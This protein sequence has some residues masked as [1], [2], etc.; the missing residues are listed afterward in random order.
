MPTDKLDV[1]ATC[2][3]PSVQKVLGALRCLAGEGFLRIAV[4]YGCALTGDVRIAYTYRMAHK[5]HPNFE[6]F[7]PENPYNLTRRQ[8]VLPQKWVKNF[9]GIGF[10]VELFDKKRLKT[11]R[12]RPNEEEFVVYRLWEERAEKLSSPIER[13]FF[14]AMDSVIAFP[15]KTI[16]NEFHRAFSA[17]YGLWE[18]RAHLRRSPP[19]DMHLLGI[20]G[21]R[22]TKSPWTKDEEE[23]LERG[24]KTFNRRDAEGG[25]YIPARLGTWTQIQVHIANVSAALAEC[26]WCVI[27]S[28][29]GNFICPDQ[30]LSRVTLL[31]LSPTICVALDQPMPY[32]SVPKSTVIGI[33]QMLCNGADNYFFSMNLSECPR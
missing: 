20:Q 16:S 33:N 23:Q 32:I 27:T 28:S 30:P 8:H 21:P 5:R 9:A 13:N 18:I 25:A 22:G 24:G 14:K 15:K 12:R 4:S 6:E 7:Q 10:Y 19:T 1:G 3:A 11:S 26:R 2:E 17:M 31:P 29:E